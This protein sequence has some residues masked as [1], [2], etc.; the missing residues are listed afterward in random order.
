MLLEILE[1]QKKL[2]AWLGQGKR[3]R[4]YFD[5]CMSAIAEC[6][7]LNEEF[8]GCFN[9][10]TWK[11]K[12]YNTEK[13]NKE[14]VDILFFLAQLI[15]KSTSQT[16][17]KNF[18]L[19]LESDL[20]LGIENVFNNTKLEP[21]RPLVNLIY[22]L[23]YTSENYGLSNS[24]EKTKDSGVRANLIILMSWYGRLCGE[25]KVDYET[26]IKLYNEKMEEN[27]NREDFKKAVAGGINENN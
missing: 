7:E 2:D 9:H 25:L 11:P 21:N 27:L 24:D 10:K 23:T 8:L 22:W 3:D 20:K 6:V 13:R 12:V 5:I 17:D 1:K 15:N 18:I 4:N 19:D 26:L 16:E 14:L